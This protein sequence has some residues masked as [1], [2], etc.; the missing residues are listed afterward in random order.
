MTLDLRQLLQIVQQRW[1]IVA[2]LMAVVGGLMYGSAKQETPTYSTTATMLVNPGTSAA[3]SADYNTFL[4]TER[5]AAT[6]QELVTA[7]PMRDRLNTTLEDRGVQVG[8]GSG[9]G[10]FEYTALVREGSQIVL[11]TATGPDPQLVA[12]VANTVVTEFPEY[13]AEMADTRTNTVLAG[14][15]TQIEDMETRQAEIDEQLS[16][17]D[18]PANDDN[19]RI[20]RQ[21]DDL[22]AE[23]AT[24]RDALLDL[25]QQ[26]LTFSTQIGASSTLIQTLAEAPVPTDPVAP[27][28][29]RSLVLGLFIGALLGATVV[30]LQEF[31]DNTMKPETNTQVLTGAP[32]LATISQ[33]S[34]IGSGWRQVFTMSQ[35]Q[36]PAAESL[37]LLR[38]N[39]EFASATRPIHSLTVSSASPGEGKSTI[40]A[41]LGVVMAQS[42]LSTVLIDADLRK[43]T[44]HDIFEKDNRAGLTTLLTHPEQEWKSVAQRTAP[45]GLRVITSGPIPPNP[46]DLLSSETFERLVNRIKSEV[47]LVIIDSPPVLAASDAL[48]IANH[49]DGVVVIALSGKTRTDTVRQAARSIHQGGIRLIGVVLNRQKGQHPETYHGEYYPGATEAAVI[50]LP[51]ANAEESTH[52]RRVAGDRG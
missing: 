49:T 12:L 17:L 14:I 7:P 2:L 43:P 34:K 35:P 29:Q 20:Q 18:V 27:Q 50:A 1:W 40:A 44:Q 28:P 22:T 8:V 37:R 36:S 15:E 19:A 5:L 4:I 3:P 38:T 30:A 23:R 31:L 21:I 9:S 11:I 10:G 24:N 47:D 13:V 45:Q 6:Y 41:N 46:S 25:K 26:A 33:V 52:R 42:G 32:L 16:E 48:A 51:Q 39:L